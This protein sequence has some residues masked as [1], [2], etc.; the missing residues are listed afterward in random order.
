[1]LFCNWLE[2]I[3]I[4][5][6]NNII[7]GQTPEMTKLTHIPLS[8][9]TTDPNKLDFTLDFQIRP[10]FTMYN[11]D[12]QIIS[13]YPEN[14]QANIIFSIDYIYRKGDQDYGIVLKVH[15]GMF[16]PHTKL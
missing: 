14:G 15:Q 8:C 2:T 11:Q 16:I 10:D 5:K 1:M 9:I 4:P 13:H 3:K 7:H 6:K 12:R